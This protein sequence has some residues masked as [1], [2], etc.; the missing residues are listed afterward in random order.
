VRLIIISSSTAAAAAAAATAVLQSGTSQH[1]FVRM[2]AGN[3]WI[4]PAMACSSAATTVFDKAMDNWV[5]IGPAVG[6]TTHLEVRLTRCAYVACLAA[7]WWRAPQRHGQLGAHV[8]G[9]P[10]LEEV[11]SLK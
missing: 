3:C 11:S 8:V 7:G 6:E 9:P 2:S 10:A 4:Y 1:M 5:C